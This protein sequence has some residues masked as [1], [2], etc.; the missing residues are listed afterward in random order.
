MTRRTVPSAA[1]LALAVFVFSAR[2]ESRDNDSAAYHDARTRISIADSTQSLI[3]AADAL[4]AEGLFADALELLAELSPGNAGTGGPPAD[5]RTAWR[6]STGV[7]YYHLED[8]DTVAM[9]SEQLRDYQRLTET[10]L[11]VWLRAKAAFTPRPGLLREI[12]PEALV[13][14]RKVRL[15]IPGRLAFFND[16][17]LLEPALKAEKWFRADG[18]ADSAFDPFAGQPSDMGGLLFRLTPGNTAR[19]GCR[20]LWSVPV[21]IDWEHYRRNRPGYESFVEYRIAPALEARSAAFPVSARMDGEVRYGNY[22]GGGADSLDVL[23]LLCR[24]ETALRSDKGSAMFGVSWMGDRYMDAQ[25]PSATDR[26]EAV[27]RGEYGAPAWVRPRLLVRG[28]YEQERYDAPAAFTV[29]GTQLALRPAAGFPIG[30]IFI[31]EPEAA[32]EWR[33]A[34]ADTSRQ[35]PYLWEARTVFEPGI[36]LGLANTTLDL[37]LRSAY[38]AEN[39]GEEFEAYTADSRSLRLGADANVILMKICTVSMSADY[40]YR[41]YAPHGSSGRVSENLTVSGSIAVRL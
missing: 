18:T 28:G 29:G 5:R 37:S 34:R 31:V 4:A 22:F 1:W 36:R 24:G 11:S 41:S 20:I 6:L 15:E 8:V 7:D 21:T 2:A 19:S 32:W 30:E 13:S 3:T 17:L 12:A 38:R 16:G 26:A 27:L 9:T 25:A 10:P 35:V 33:A 39:I 40:Q 14:E 23:R